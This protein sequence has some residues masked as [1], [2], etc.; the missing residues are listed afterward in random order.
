MPKIIKL[1]G[2]KCRKMI[3]GETNEKEE[4]DKT[5][6][7]IWLSTPVCIIKYM[8]DIE[9]DIH[10]RIKIMLLPQILSLRK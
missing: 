1:G 2:I 5:Y 3:N 10:L 4:N 8:T 9:H 6:F 7:R